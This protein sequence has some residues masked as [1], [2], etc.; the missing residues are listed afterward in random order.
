MRPPGGHAV[1]LDARA[2][3]PHIAALSYPGQA[4][5][6]QQGVDDAGFTGIGAAGHG[7]LP[8]GIGWKLTWL[9]HALE[10]GDVGKL[11]HVGRSVQLTG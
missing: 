9:G 7:H 5:A 3:L 4:L 10:E 11:A 1:Y 8:A 6:V 2:L